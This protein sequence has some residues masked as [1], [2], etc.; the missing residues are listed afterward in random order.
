MKVTIITA[1]TGGD[2]LANCIDSVRNQTY[3]DYEHIVVVDGK[4]KWDG[5]DPIL[6]AAE[7]PNVSNEH[8][9]ILPYATGLNRFNGH[10]IYA[11]FTLLAD[12]DYVCWLDDDNEFTP[13]HLESLVSVV[14]EK[15]LDWAYSLRQ[16]IDSE[17]NFICN[18]DCENLGKWKS[19]LNDHFVDVSCFFVKREVAVQLAP[20]WYRPARPGNGIMEVD[21]ALTAV[22]MHE[23]NKL[24]FDTNADYTVK[25]RVGST[26]ISVRK[27]FFLEGNAAMLN[28]Y[29]GKLPWKN[30]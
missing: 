5:T 8:L 17:G 28:R 18:D 14:K 22:L 30:K 3:R 1:T 6:K 16:I 10:R 27:E 19:I 20:V 24:K 9:M 11:A 12:C 26:G 25:Y 15:N 21:R 23:N 4:N 2:R 29:S 7:F 13:N